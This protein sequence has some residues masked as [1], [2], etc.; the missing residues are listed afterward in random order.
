VFLLW[1][2]QLYRQQRQ[3]ISNIAA[4]LGRSLQNTV[5]TCPQERGPATGND[6]LHFDME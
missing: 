3:A 5:K 2:L 1:Q 6:A 4:D